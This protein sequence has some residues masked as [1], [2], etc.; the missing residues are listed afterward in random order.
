MNEQDDL[1]S[2]RFSRYYDGYSF[3]LSGD[4]QF[5]VEEASETG[6][7]SSTCLIPGWTC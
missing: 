2:D 3:G 7:S 1:Y 4:V 6:C 5:Y